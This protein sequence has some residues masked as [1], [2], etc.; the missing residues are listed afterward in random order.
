[1]NQSTF[2]FESV[3]DVSARKHQGSP[4]SVAANAKASKSKTAW[5]YLCFDYIKRHGPA[6]L[7]EI[8]DHFGKT[9]NQLSGRLSALRFDGKIEKTGEVRN[10]FAVYRAA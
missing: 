2:D 8:C 4:T 3:V 6:T 9:P 5:R 10:G 1:M 7:E